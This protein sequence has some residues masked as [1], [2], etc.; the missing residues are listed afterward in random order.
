MDAQHHATIADKLMQYRGKL[1]KHTNPSN[2]IAVG[3]TYD[4][5]K[6][7]EDLLWIYLIHQECYNLFFQH[8]TNV[9][10]VAFEI[11]HDQLSDDFRSRL[12]EIQRIV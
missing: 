1:P 2:R 8:W 11:I 5:K 4:L 3:L 10:L 7:I 12:F 6:H 9:D